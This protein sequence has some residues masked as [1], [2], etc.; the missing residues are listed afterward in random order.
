VRNTTVVDQQSLH[1]KGYHL[2]ED[3]ADDAIGWLRRHKAF[4]PDKPFFMYRASGASHGP[5]HVAKA[6]ADKYSG[7]FDD[8]WDKYRERVFKRA[9]EMGWI[10]PNAQL[11]PRPATLSARESIPDDEKPFQRRLMEVYAGFTEHVDVQVG[12]IVDEVDKLGYGDNTLVFYIWGDNGASAEGQNG[13]ISE[14]PAQNGIPTTIQQH[15]K[16]LNDLGGLDV[17]GSPETDN[18]YH[19]GWAW[20]GSPPTRRPSWSPP[21]LVAR[22]IP[23]PCA[24]LPRLSPTPPHAR[25]STM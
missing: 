21:T 10:P 18:M 24:G 3:L 7:K 14:L 19:A 12:R 1:R 25:S 11:T 16:A 5:H 23:W 8:G 4:Q 20:A 6:W 17:L 15:I 2:S 9:K 13:T 22:A